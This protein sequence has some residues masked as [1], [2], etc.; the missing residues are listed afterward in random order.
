[1]TSLELLVLAAAGGFALSHGLRLPVIPLLV[2]LGFLVGNAGLD[3]DRE[4]VKDLMGLGLVFLVYAAGIELNPRRFAGKTAAVLWAAVVQFVVLALGGFV[5]ALALGF[6]RDEALYL[7]GALATSSTLVVVRQLQSRV[8]S[9]RS[10]GRLAI[11]VL[12]VQDLAIIVTIVVLVALPEGP[13][14][15]LARAAAVLLLGGVALLLQ[16]QAFPRFV[17]RTRQDDEIV[18][19]LLVAVLFLFAG[20]ASVLGLPFVVGAFFAGF[21]LSAFPVNGVARSL[22]RSMTSFSL[23]I[24]FTGLGAMLAWPTLQVVLVSAAFVALVLLVTPPLVAAIAEWKA[25]LSSRNALTSGLLLAQTSEFSLI[26]GLY[27]L[28]LERI[29]PEVMAVITMVAVVTMTISPL[30]ASDRTARRLLRWHPLHRRMTTA[31]DLRDHVVVLG[32]GSE[33][34]WVVKPLLAAG[35]RVVVVDHDPVVIEHLEKAGVHCV[36]GDATDEKCLL[37][38]GIA[39]ARVVLLALP[40]VDDAVRVLRR[41]TLPDIPVVVRVFEEHHAHEIERHGGIPVLNSHAAADRFLEWFDDSMPR[42][43]PGA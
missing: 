36:R 17:L 3:T 37:R 30:V 1:M 33:G 6:G 4:A 10:Y 27:A 21:S 14:T 22:L 43:A 29:R 20:A 35:H 28:H 2:L 8:G 12:L 19:L 42:R 34:M 11:G 7:G 13:G 25:G 26:L 18:L 9:L 16:R 32:F 23:A 24:F 5:L 31:S 38:A 15:V 41:H 39:R 40:N